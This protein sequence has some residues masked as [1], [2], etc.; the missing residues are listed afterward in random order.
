MAKV[1]V[2]DDHAVVR[3][4]VKMLLEKNGHEVVG[5]YSG[6]IEALDTLKAGMAELLVLDIDMPQIDGFGVL[7]RLKASKSRCKVIVFTS[8]HP[9]QYANRCARA[10]AS[11]FVSKQDDLSELTIVA[12]MVLSGYKVF[13]TTMSSSVAK[14]SQEHDEASMLAR[15]SAREVGILRLLIR[16]ERLVDIARQVNLSDKTVSAYKSRVMNKLEVNNIFELI[17]LATRNN[18]K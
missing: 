11:A 17:D 18:I 12:K 14:T 16:G 3:M 9:N 7:Q 8:L 1:I 4:A 2:V 5:E 6:G 10:G 13:P 15:L